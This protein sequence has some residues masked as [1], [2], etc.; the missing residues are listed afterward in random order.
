[1]KKKTKARSSRLNSL[2]MVLMLT[3]VLL[4]MSTYAWFTANRTVNIDKIDVKVATSSGL[5]ISADGIEW[6]TVLEKSDIVDA[7]KTY[8]SS[9]NQL[10]SLMA[11]VS[12][13][14]ELDATGHL[15]MFYGK[16]E[17]DMT[18]GSGTYGQ[19][20][21]T[22]TLQTDKASDEVTTTGEYDK[23]YY[24]A[25]DVFLKVETPSDKLYMSG[26]VSEPITDKGLA[27]AARIALIKG[28][29]TVATSASTS[30]IQSLPT[31]GGS[32]VMWEPNADTHTANGVNNATALGW[33]SLTA[34]EGNPTVAYDGSLAEASKVVLADATA[35]KNPA[36]F[37]KTT[38]NWATAKSGTP[39]LEMPSGLD[40]GITKYRVYLW[41]EGQDVDCE[42][43]ASGTDVQYDMTFSL[44]PIVG[45]G[46]GG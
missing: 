6:K 1:M 22:T 33:A 32:V 9:V 8:D 14:L 36:A 31:A 16:V 42:N 30:E 44:D 5:Q 2:L 24:M 43:N 11:P 40:A 38:P 3:A 25:F 45:T 23:G 34:G 35:A 19:Y 17:A 13:A 39:S 29:N 41:I 37:Q 46:T 27:N 21:L 26:A 10:P 15:K 28:P 12:S 20:L 7:F 18:V 4:I